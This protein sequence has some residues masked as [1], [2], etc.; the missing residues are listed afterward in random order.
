MLTHLQIGAEIDI[1]SGDELTNGLKD[2]E[3]KLGRR[4]ARPTYLSFTQRRL[5]AGVLVLGSPPAGRMWNIV[6]WTL[7]GNDDATVIAN[8]LAA[9][10]VDSQEDNLSLANCRIPGVV[11][12]SFTTITKGTLWAHSEGSVVVNISGAVGATDQI[13]STISVQ[14]WRIEDVEDRTPGR[15]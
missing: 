3:D 2:L 9:L 12:P 1:A 13:V 15:Y 5:G 10:Y 6:T 7:A 8:A 4:V 11:V 14:E